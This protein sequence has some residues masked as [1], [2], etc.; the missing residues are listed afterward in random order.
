MP[1]RWI[2]L[3]FVLSLALAVPGSAHAEVLFQEDFS[4][5][6][7]G[8]SLGPEWMIGPTAT[9]VGHT[10]GW[11][12]PEFDHSTS[13]D[14]GVA[15]TILG[16]N[17][18]TFVHPA[19]YLTS[20]AIDI[21]SATG[22]LT[23]SFWR[24]LNSDYPSFMMPTVEVFDGS[25]WVVIWHTN[26]SSAPVADNAWSQ[27]SFDVTPYKNAQFRVRFG[28][29]VGQGGAFT[30]SG[31]NVDDLAIGSDGSCTDADGDG[32]VSA[33]CGGSDCND[34]SASVYPG[35]PE[36]CNGID[37]NCDGNVDENS[38]NW[39]PDLDSDGFGDATATPV[40]A[41]SAPANHVSN[42]SDCDD[43][44]SAV[45]PAAFE[46]CNGLDDNCNA[47]VDEYVMV[48][49]YADADG[50]GFGNP[51]DVVES[52]TPVTGRV[53][54][55]LDCDDTNAAR[56]PVA[57]ELLDGLDNNCNGFV[58][59]GFE[60]PLIRSIRDVPGDQGR[61]V[62]VRW[63]KDLRER[64][65]SPYDDSP[66]VTG[67]QL[68]RRVEPGQ[69]AALRAK[70][71]GAEALALPPGDWDI[72]ANVSATLDSVYQM[73][74][75]TLCDSTGAGICWSRFVVRAITQYAGLYYDSPVDS[76]YS[77]DNLAPNVPAGLAA[78]P[79]AGG[80]QLDWQP[81]TAGDFRYFRIY[82]GASP[83]FTPGPASLVHETTGTSW[84]NLV[85]GSFTYKV[86]A[87]DFNDNE[88]APA[89]ASVTV[90]VDGGAVPTALGFA[91]VSPNPFRNSVALAVDVPA[92]GE[93]AEAR[94]FDLAGREVRTLARGLAPGRHVLAWDGRSDSGARLAPGVY[95]A[96][97]TGGGR[98]VTRRVTLV[99]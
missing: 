36:L 74:V 76:G 12:D 88:S 55:Y 89:T 19:Y 81:S 7:A 73:T 8:W 58:D 98:V 41:C 68:Y 17:A 83:D 66:M 13:T 23:L 93:G 95:L 97:L 82:R 72:V 31:W 67:Y 96:R 30:M 47:Y 42:A 90:G 86:T 6:S 24:W 21:S 45:H 64:A 91:S 62:R 15:G 32:H 26:G 69:A 51:V 60:I 34:S 50:D 59:E 71:E 10:H 39:Y 35:A 70:P 33:A 87:V 37:D 2:R 77:I 48:L 38:Q 78:Q 65:Y 57:S 79:V 54:N 84:T 20:P 14:N 61:V 52:C 4:D 1:R 75:P 43:A 63:R 99:P 46:V 56:S 27:Q 25:S 44:N 94:V 9:S 16:G 11:S 92:G 80:V 3:A 18:S 5:N 22:L 40:V 85:S 28:L 29:A 49:W 53:D